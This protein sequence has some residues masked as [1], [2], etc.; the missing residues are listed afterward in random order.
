MNSQIAGGKFNADLDRFSFHYYGSNDMYVPTASPAPFASLKLVTDRIKS[1]LETLG[2]GDIKLFVSE[3][4]ATVDEGTDI[5]DSH[6]G[7]AWTAAFLNEAV[8][9]KIAIGSY[10]ILSDGLVDP[11]NPSRR[12]QASLMHKEVASDGSIHYYP[13]PVAN[14][15]K[16]FARMSGTRRQAIV[17]PSG[18]NSDLGAFAAS[19]AGSASVVVF[20]YNRMLVFQNNDNALPDMPETFTVSL[21]NLPFDGDVT[22]QRYQ[23]DAA[24]SNLK[25]FLDDPGHPDPN[26]QMVQ[27]TGHRER[28]VDTAAA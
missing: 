6:K 22:I 25:A 24:T 18:A 16:M 23:V 15:L 19:D 27:T 13:K 12:G 17:S 8:A 2:R 21:T 3:W 14:V 26:L 1:K 4:G 20:N 28:T 5:N 9:Q 10:L 11:D 7:A